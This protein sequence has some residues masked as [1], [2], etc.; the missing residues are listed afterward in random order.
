VLQLIWK[1]KHSSVLMRARTEEA[2]EAAKS[3]DDGAAEERNPF[4]AR[5]HMIHKFHSTH[6][7]GQWRKLTVYHPRRRGGGLRRLMFPPLSLRRRW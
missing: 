2:D 5:R 1:K 3:G 7:K 4:E 6:I